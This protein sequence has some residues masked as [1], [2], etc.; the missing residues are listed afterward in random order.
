MNIK[1]SF[2]V[3]LAGATAFATLSSFAVSAATPGY[4]DGAV[5]EQ[6]ASEQVTVTEGKATSGTV[7]FENTDIAVD[8]EIPADV[9]EAGSV[10][11]FNA[12]VVTDP[13]VM[14]LA[15]SIDEIKDYQ[16]LDLFFTNED[17][18]VIDMAGKNVVVTIKVSGY[19][20]VY[21]FNGT[22]FEDMGAVA[23]E[24]T[25]TFTASHFSTYV[26]ANV[27]TSNDDDNVTPGT[28]TDNNNNNNNSNNNNNNSNNAGTTQTGDNGFVTTIVIF[29]IMAVISLATAVVATKAKKSSK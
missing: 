5:E 21:Y 23:G 8:F 18:V 9:V 16:V 11:E 6:V 28:S 26:L 20:A 12:A 3:A 13:A 7:E 1:K 24:G 19:N 17:G 22:S 25:L 2:L 15:E 29:S 4:S 14:D 27:E 10:L